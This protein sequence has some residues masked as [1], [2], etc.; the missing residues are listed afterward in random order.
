MATYNIIQRDQNPPKEIDKQDQSR[1]KRQRHMTVTYPTDVTREIIM[2]ILQ[3]TNVVQ[4]PKMVKVKNLDSFDN[5]VSKKNEKYDQINDDY[6]GPFV[7]DESDLDIPDELYFQ[8][9]EDIDENDEELITDYV[10]DSNSKS[11]ISKQPIEN[12]IVSTVNDTIKGASEIGN[13]ITDKLDKRNIPAS[14][15]IKSVCNIIPSIRACLWGTGTLMLNEFVDED[16]FDISRTGMVHLGHCL[17]LALYFHKNFLEISKQATETR[18]M[19]PLREAIQ[20]F[21]QEGPTHIAMGTILLAVGDVLDSAAS[22]TLVSIGCVAASLLVNRMRQNN[23]RHA[24]KETPNAKTQ[25]KN[26]E[27]LTEK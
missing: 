7:Y 19:Q 24:I 14:S 18:A 25:K 20:E 5:L 4:P 2:E 15:L 1:N 27:N 11:V 10:P 3:E 21:K 23:L 8:D 22:D 9:Q 6:D 26:K 12:M 17:T 16:V 13:N